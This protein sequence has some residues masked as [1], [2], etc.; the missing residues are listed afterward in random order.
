MT[1]DIK[2]K[3]KKY[4]IKAIST[5]IIDDNIKIVGMS[6]FSWIYGNDIYM[7]LRKDYPLK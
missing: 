5:I 2:V 3:M 4:G 7:R 6:D 1:N